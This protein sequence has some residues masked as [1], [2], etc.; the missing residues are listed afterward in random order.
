MLACDFGGGKQKRLRILLQA[1]A[2][3]V[4]A[5]N[6]CLPCVI[7]LRCDFVHGVRG[8]NTSTIT[9]FNDY[10]SQFNNYIEL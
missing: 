3:C 6:S 9:I 7:N 1:G 8:E 4:S 2:G 10:C 5:E